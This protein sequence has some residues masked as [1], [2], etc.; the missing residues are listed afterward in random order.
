MAR[1]STASSPPGLGKARCWLAPRLLLV[2]VLLV[3]LLLLLLLP[4]VA[5]FPTWWL[6]LAAAVV[7]V[8]VVLIVLVLAVGVRD[9]LVA[10]VVDVAVGVGA[11]GSCYTAEDRSDRRLLMLVS[12]ASMP[13]PMSTPVSVPLNHRAA[14]T[15]YFQFGSDR[16]MRKYGKNTTTNKEKGK[17][18]YTKKG[19]KA[20]RGQL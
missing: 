4:S 6:L 8:V 10:T 5:L 17:A 1:A 14:A 20:K 15:Y 11:L 16:N 13:M 9:A 12:T 18:A 2:P 3:V 19:K 7:V